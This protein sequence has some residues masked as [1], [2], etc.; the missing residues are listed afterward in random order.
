MESVFNSLDPRI[1]SMLD[2]IGLNT[3][4]E[5]QEKLI[6]LVLEGRNALL[7]SPTGTGKTEAAMLPIFHRILAT[8][9]RPV[10]AIY[11]TPLRALNRDMLSRLM[12]YGN[13]VGIRIQVRHS[14]L[15]QADRARI[16]REPAD[17]LITTPES[18]QILLKGKR[19]REIISSTK[20][21]VVDEMH[22]LSQTERGSQ[23]FVALERLESL[24]GGFQRIGLSATVGNPEELAQLLSPG[25]PVNVVVA[26]PKKTVEINVVIPPKS[27]EEFAEVMGC[28]EQYAGSIMFI[29][30]LI[31]AHSGTL[32]FVNTRSVAEDMAF[33]L[34][35]W[36]GSDIPILVHHGSLSRETRE[37]AEREFKSGKVKALICTSSLELGIDIGSA[38]LVIQFNSPR[39]VNRL[40]QRVGRSG[41]WIKRISR[42]YVICNDRIELEEASAI[43]D[44]ALSGFIESVR[45]RKGSLATLANQVISELNCTGKANIIGL[46]STMHGSYPYS[47]VTLDDFRTLLSFLAQIKK[48]WIEGETV[49]RRGSSL[50]YFIENI[51]MIP[52]EKNYKVID[53]T[54]KKFIGTLDERYVLNEIEP[55]SYF[56]MKGATW[57]TRMV[58]K[59]KIL[60]EPFSTAAIAPKWTGEDIPVPL[61]VARRVSSIRSG[62]R[63]AFQ[64]EPLSA[65]ALEEL[66]S[67]ALGTFE[68]PLIET[69]NGEIMIQTMLG[70]KG[71]FGLA[72]IMS[73][74]LTMISGE[75]VEMDYSPYHIYFRV[76]RRITPEEVLRVVMG[77]EPEKL[78]TYVEGLCRRSR[79]F[80]GVFLYE[81]RKFGI[82][83]ADA[84]IGRIRFEKI[85]DSYFGTP[86][87][88]DA[89]NKLIWDYMDLDLL[90]SYLNSIR[91]G[92]VSFS[93][94][95]GIGGHSRDFLSHYSERVLPL[96]PT[97]TILESIRK[98]ILNEQTTLLCTSCGNVRTMK[99]REAVSIR[100]PACGSSLVASL[101]DYELNEYR[102]NP[103][104]RMV[105]RR[106][107]RNAHLIRERGFQAIMALAAHGIG[108]ETA[109]RLLE[110]SYINEEDFMRAILNAEM[111]FAKNRRFWD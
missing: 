101:S 107:S 100:C 72:E 43:V 85:V 95:D 84:E 13:H 89:V 65:L 106:V 102:S 4:T 26:T 47:D 60:V 82:I 10:S 110:V 111:E 104:D 81:A 78:E 15:S 57:R 87:Y 68:V 11:V 105:R 39:Q 52:S 88:R 3:P 53:V 6:P 51:S 34:H 109:I 92:A 73:G 14:D 54:A 33:R 32:V 44:L 67:T 74:M 83:S 46:Y 75:S 21:V 24:T 17:V 7:V 77:I 99:V 30:K 1:L 55:G 23:F 59:E 62:S 2:K 70:T 19:L 48:V 94:K 20:Y 80:S 50:T 93:L 96:K 103:D 36:L 40:I 42:G 69:Q 79:F 18:L 41:H 91:S 28:D 64:L 16:V 90:R 58:D 61:A 45:I 37:T 108:P 97:K 56:V 76:S 86:V 22:E 38:D 49:G 98:R 8:R 27:T 66:H 12:D 31:Q 71:N 35:M 29:W 9:P 5:A 25:R 63:L